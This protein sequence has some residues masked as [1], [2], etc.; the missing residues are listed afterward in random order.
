MIVLGWNTLEPS[1]V[2]EIGGR[3]NFTL[4]SLRLPGFAALIAECCG[5]LGVFFFFA[6]I[7]YFPWKLLSS[8]FLS[9]LL[10]SS[11]SVKPFGPLLLFVGRYFITNSNSLLVINPFLLSFSSRFSLGRLFISRNLSYPSRLSFLLSYNCLQWSLMIL[12]I[13]AG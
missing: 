3:L 11:S 9:L 5:R 8:Y 13:S 10:P 4:R 2:M 12:C 1:G 7:L 6:L